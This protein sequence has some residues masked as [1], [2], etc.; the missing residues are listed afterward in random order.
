MFFL[1]IVQ[2][3]LRL[4]AISIQVCWFR[5]GHPVN[6]LKWQSGHVRH[7]RPPFSS[8]CSSKQLTAWKRFVYK[9]SK[10]RSLPQVENNDC[11]RSSGPRLACLV[12]R[13]HNT[14]FIQHGPSQGCSVPTTREHG[15]WTRLLFWTHVYTHSAFLFLILS[16]LSSTLLFSSG[17]DYFRATTTIKTKLQLKRLYARLPLRKVLKNR[18]QKL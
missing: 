11:D 6:T 16:L 3:W 5:V 8:E 12:G 4:L 15:P 9:V 1:F 2:F 13:L 14:A 7:Y 18:S 17:I 10:Y